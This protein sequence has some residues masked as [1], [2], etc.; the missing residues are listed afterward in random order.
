[1]LAL[2]PSAE[3]IVFEPNHS[4]YK[5]V[6]RIKVAEGSTYASPVPSG[7]RLFIK[8]QDSVMLL[9]GE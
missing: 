1:M 3:L 5:E 8:D 2:T 6:A 4:A 7:N 9:T